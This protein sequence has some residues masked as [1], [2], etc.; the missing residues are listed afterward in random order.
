M[1]I[2]ITITFKLKEGVRVYVDADK[3]TV[4]QADDNGNGPCEA[5]E[6]P[7]FIA[8]REDGQWLNAVIAEVYIWDRVIDVDEMTLAM[9]TIG[10][11]AVQ[12]GGKLTTT[13]G[14]MKRR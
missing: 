3:A 1:P 8:H 2:T 9:K 13:W 12:P 10:G 14:N 5:G 11:L 6:R 7:V 4:A